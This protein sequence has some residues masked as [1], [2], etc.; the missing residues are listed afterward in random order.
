MLRRQILGL[1]GALP[2]LALADDAPAG[3]SSGPA[4]RLV[5]SDFRG[6]EPQVLEKAGWRGF[7]DRVM[8]GV[9]DSAFGLDE[10]DGIA[11]ARLTGTVTRD[12]GGGFV[13]MALDLGRGRAGFDASGYAGLELLIRGND[14]DY[15]VH[16]RT[17]AVRWYDQSYRATIHVEPRWQT[18]R[19]PWTD[20]TPHG[21]EGPV[22]TSSLRRIGLLGW[23]REF[24]A[25][26]ALAQIALYA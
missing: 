15:N 18:I 7:S 5:L 22:D 3:G 10:V 20:F 4:K 16:L 19:I 1:A 21:L 8:G 17:A 11:C 25:D 2:V 24:E 23:M 26:L 12:N 6:A 9:S 14:E 13:Q